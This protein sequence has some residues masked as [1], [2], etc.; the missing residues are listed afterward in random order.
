M[1]RSDLSMKDRASYIK[2][3]VENGIYNLNSIRTIYNSFA[4]GGPIKAMRATPTLKK[5]SWETD[6]EYKER[7]LSI[8]N[9][10]IQNFNSTVVEKEDI[11]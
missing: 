9:K 5:K 6:E 11:K 8:V 4:E 1:N 7:I 2:L 10:K 3:M